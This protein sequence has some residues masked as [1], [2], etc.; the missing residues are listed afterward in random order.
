MEN[1]TL[2]AI[3]LIIGSLLLPLGCGDSTGPMLASLEVSPTTAT[4]TVIGDTVRFTAV[5]RDLEG[6]VSGAGWTWLSSNPQ[7]A[8]VGEFSG[9]ATAVANGTTLIRPLIACGDGRCEGSAT[10]TVA[11]P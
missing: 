6:N 8:T 4:L 9:L 3:P 1:R 11:A 5:A 2:I 7:V 10:L